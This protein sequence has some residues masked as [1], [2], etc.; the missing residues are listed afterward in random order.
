M[1]DPIHLPKLLGLDVEFSNTLE[2]HH[3]AERCSA[4]A[5]K[6]LA[7]IRGLPRDEH[8]S[9]HDPRPG[10][11]WQGWPTE[12]DLGRRFLSANGACFYIDS[13]HLEAATSE[14]LN[15]RENLAT[16]HGA[17]RIV[18][19]A[20]ARANA[21][22]PAG[23]HLRVAV[24][25]SDGFSKSFG[26]H[27]NTLL[28][29]AALNRI[30]RHRPTTEWLAAFQVSSVILTG[31]GKVGSEN[32]QP[33]CT[34]QL[35][36]RAD[37]FERLIDEETMYRRPIINTRDEPL[38]GR[39]DNGHRRCHCILHD[40]NLCH[41][42]HF[43][44]VGT[45][46][47]ALTMIE[48]GAIDDRVCLADPVGALIGFSHDPT[49]NAR[50]ALATGGSASA[51]DLQL[52]FCEAAAS[53]VERGRCEGLVPEA[54]AIVALWQDTLA[55]LER[56]DFC[57]LARR[58]DWV[59]KLNLIESALAASPRLN[60]QSPEV[61]LLDQNYG[62][63]ESGMFWQCLDAGLVERLVSDAEIEHTTVA[64]PEGTR[65]WTRA[66]LLALA[67]AE[68]VIHVDWDSITV[69][70]PDGKQR[71]VWLE[72]PLG[73][74][75]TDSPI[76]EARTFDEALAALEK[77]T[78]PAPIYTAYFHHQTTTL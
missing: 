17:I 61:R 41:A 45:M 5:W 21:K 72:N 50:A 36:Q 55:K 2:G 56:R 29:S 15:A 71:I 69:R 23:Q 40:A 11:G 30:F 3:P 4:A 65:A 52:R 37:F 73:F 66:R 63:L 34:F 32:G 67:P 51:L 7:E 13:G 27:T 12:R 47:I 8:R 19:D 49:L 20:Q 35:S 1:K 74:T 31:A 64:A 48:A 57:A 62:D 44:K 9:L 77:H 25:N 78:T 18:R 22:L 6:L 60:W 26:S 54:K 28:T 24:A 38:C 59:L 75:R 53:F 76:R 33:P 70:L 68:A 58:L 39:R 42:A 46:Q 43:L 10:H 14:T 16:W